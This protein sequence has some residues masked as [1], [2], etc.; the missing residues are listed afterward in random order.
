MML[1]IRKSHPKKN[2]KDKNNDICRKGPYVIKYKEQEHVG[3]SF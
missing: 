2:F 1:E 3:K